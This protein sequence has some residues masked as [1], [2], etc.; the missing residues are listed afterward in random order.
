MAPTAEILRELRRQV[1]AAICVAQ[2]IPRSRTPLQR[3][4]YALLLNALTALDRESPLPEAFVIRIAAHALVEW[5][6]HESTGL[7]IIDGGSADG[8]R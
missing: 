7:S 2:E 3:M 6:R 8:R 1:A 5:R 4:C